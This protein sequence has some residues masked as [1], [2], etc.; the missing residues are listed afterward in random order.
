MLLLKRG[1]DIFVSIILLIL[2]LPVFIIISLSIKLES[3]GPAFF[4]QERAGIWGKPF[5]IYKFRTMI[6]DAINI[7][8]G[9]YTAQNDPRIT[10]VGRVLRDW[11]L[12]ELPQ[13]FNILK[14]D[15][16]IIG[17]RP[18]LVY[19]IEEYDVEQRKR[20]NMKPGVTGLAQVN[21]RN[22]LSWPERIK[23]DIWYVENWSVWLD[24]KIMI[25][26]IFVI[27]KREGV[28]GTED[29]FVIKNKD[30]IY[31]KNGVDM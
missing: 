13:L 3:K 25:K 16:S 4:L 15:M 1:F 29:K 7:G 10:K 27:F 26:T 18:T 5:Q 24:I 17:P 23:Y 31:N 8:T 19:Q 30:K 2:L 11:S 14:G 28:Y 6:V 9:F 22:L 21:G 20:L 12:D